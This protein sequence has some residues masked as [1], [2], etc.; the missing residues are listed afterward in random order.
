[1][2]KIR[3]LKMLVRLF[4]SVKELASIGVRQHL[5]R[6]HVYSSATIAA[7]GV[8]A[9]LLVHMAKGRNVHATTTSK[10]RKARINVHEI[11]NYVEKKKA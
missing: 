8:C 9:F 3:T 2:Y 10:L 5:T 4:Q 6:S 1:M 7:R 11:I